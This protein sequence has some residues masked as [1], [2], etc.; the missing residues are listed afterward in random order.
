MKITIKTMSGKQ[1]ALDVEET[2]TVSQRKIDHVF[3]IS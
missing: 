3:Q 2:T 1:I